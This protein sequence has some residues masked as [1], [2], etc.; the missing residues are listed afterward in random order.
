M[1]SVGYKNCK[2]YYYY[3]C[4]RTGSGAPKLGVELT[5]ANRNTI[6]A[7]LKQMVQQRLSSNQDFSSDAP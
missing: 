2:N 4:A 6:K 3:K 7:H 1:F 5:G